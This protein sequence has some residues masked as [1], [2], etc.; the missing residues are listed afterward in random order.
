MTRTHKRP[1]TLQQYRVLDE[2]RGRTYPLDK[3][4]LRT[5]SMIRHGFQ[6]TLDA[7][8]RRGAISVVHRTDKHENGMSTTHMGYISA[9]G[10]YL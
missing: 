3:A 8:L 10:R 9:R 2:L 5:L 6:R 4:E 1:F 7:L